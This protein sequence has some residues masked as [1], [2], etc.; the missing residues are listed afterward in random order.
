MYRR[1]FSV[2]LAVSRIA[3]RPFPLGSRLLYVARTFLSASR[4]SDKTACYIFTNLTIIGNYWFGAY[5]L[6]PH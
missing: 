4:R 1:F 5:L 2:A 6:Q 3:P